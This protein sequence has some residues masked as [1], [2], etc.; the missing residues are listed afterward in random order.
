[1][2]SLLEVKRNDGVHVQ[3]GRRKQVGAFIAPQPLLLSCPPMTGLGW[4]D[5]G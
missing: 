4:Q 5:V 3:D 2:P 1:M